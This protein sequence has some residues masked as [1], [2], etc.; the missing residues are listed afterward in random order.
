MKKE[1]EAE[2]GFKCLCAAK[3]GLVSQGGKSGTSEVG[4][5][6]HADWLIVLACL[7]TC[8]VV[9]TTPCHCHA[10]KAD[11]NFNFHHSECKESSVGG[12]RQ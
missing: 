11:L 12:P 5:E 9:E 10:N 3:T 6:K 1:C 2:E 7:V 4:E 8:S